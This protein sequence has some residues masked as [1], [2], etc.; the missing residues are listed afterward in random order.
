MEIPRYWARIE[1]T[2][3]GADN[4]PIDITSWGWSSIS[5]SEAERHARERLPQATARIVAAV[6]AHDESRYP[7]GA[8]PLR[9]EILRE[10]P[11][12]D[13][14]PAAILSRN[15][16]GAVV[17]NTA[18]L[19]FVD[20]DLRNPRSGCLWFLRRKSLQRIEEETL[21]R[22]RDGLARYS[23]SFR[24]YRTAGGFR[25]LGTGH[26]YE[27]GPDTESERLMK[28]VGADPSFVLLSRLQKSFRARLT[29]KPFR[30]GLPAPPQGFP[31]AGT[32][33]FEEWLARYDEAC[34]AYA[35]C[36][37]LETAG[38]GWTAAEVAP[39]VKLHDEAT[40][41]GSGL[42]LA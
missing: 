33:L 11:D 18:R 24:I 20:V 32:P 13:G 30:L 23:G 17:L 41:V 10:I 38:K 31:R 19:L 9:E 16:Y 29:P 26:L 7:Y 21:A 39:L 5:Q 2:A 36:E 22:I 4:L 15:G 27:P 37:L 42:P 40:G 8:H 12:G 28:E 3:R 14:Q 35:V 6:D 1:T 25:I 34:K